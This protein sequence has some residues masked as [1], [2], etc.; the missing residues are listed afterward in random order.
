MTWH[1]DKGTE[2]QLLARIVALLL[3]LADLAEQAAG[4]P[5]SVGQHFLLALR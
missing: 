4:A 5:G 2:T 3:S 1:A